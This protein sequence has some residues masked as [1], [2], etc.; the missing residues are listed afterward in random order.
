[1]ILSC[2]SVAKPFSW[3]AWLYRAVGF[4]KYK[5]RSFRSGIYDILSISSDRWHLPVSAATEARGNI[6]NKW[7]HARVGVVDHKIEP[8]YVKLGAAHTVC[9]VPVQCFIQTFYQGGG[10]GKLECWK[11]KEGQH[12]PPDCVAK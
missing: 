8:T 12:Q 11:C 6:C 10:G 3:P 2:V 5:P 7:Q 1:M 9:A 4:D